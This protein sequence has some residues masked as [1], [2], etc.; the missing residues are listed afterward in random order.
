MNRGLTAVMLAIGLSL[1]G[2][3]FGQSALPSSVRAAATITDEGQ[4]AIVAFQKAQIAKMA[5]N[6]P[7]A[8]N[9]GRDAL[10]AA[11][12][13]GEPAPSPQFVDAYVQ[14]L[15]DT[16][17]PLTDDPSML[18]RL[19]AAIVVGK[20]AERT[21]NLRLK[22]IV[23]KIL[24][25]KADPVVLW[26]AK[27]AGPLILAQMRA[28]VMPNDKLVAGLV[29]AIQDNL[30]GAVAQAGYEALR[31][32]ITQERDSLTE[33]MLQVTIP[34]IQKLLGAR[35][36]KYQDGIPDVPVDDTLATGFLVDSVVWKAQTPAQRLV[37]TQLI[38]DMLSLGSHRAAA[39]NAKEDQADREDVVQTLKLVGS[40]VRVIADLGGKT[41]LTS[42]AAAVMKLEPSNDGACNRPG[43]RRAGGGAC[44]RVQGRQSP[45]NRQVTGHHLAACWPEMLR[46]G[47]IFLLLIGLL[48]AAF[49]WS[50]NARAGR[51]GF[52]LHQPGRD[53]HT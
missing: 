8:R 7:K 22:P 42:A 45:G 43:M 19:N 27:A 11:V 38:V 25:D 30:S 23:S 53:R 18:M 34:Y 40:A 16:L 41:N 1:V 37:T 20:V 15:N 14:A 3:A 21:Q 10:V 6:T 13:G 52:H 31:L 46:F 50:G 4:S 33:P 35:L 39:L 36:A 2:H 51:A 49:A 47:L 24:A 48:L 5:G 28:Q 26:G 12:V 9:E 44:C 32:N 29:S 17:M